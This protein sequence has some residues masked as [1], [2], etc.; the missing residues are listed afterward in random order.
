M[1]HL[2][3]ILIFF[4][5][6]QISY[7][8]NTWSS[9]IPDP[10]RGYPKKLL[11]ASDGGFVLLSRKIDTLPFQTFYQIMVKF[12]SEGQF[13]WGKEYDFGVT[14]SSVNMDGVH[15]TSMIELDNGDLITYGRVVDID[16]TYCYLL[17]TNSNGDSL[18]MQT[19]GDFCFG[20]LQYVNNEIY[21]RHGDS[22]G[23]NYLLK[24][25]SNG[26]ILSQ[27]ELGDYSFEGMVIDEDLNV[28]TNRAMNNT[29]FRKHSIDGTLLKE[30]AY[31]DVGRFLKLGANGYPTAFSYGM[32]QLNSDLSERWYKEPDELLISPTATNVYQEERVLL[33]TSDNG[34]I[35]A[36]TYGLDFIST[37]EQVYII[38]LDE[39]GEWEWGYTYAVSYLPYTGAYDMVEVSDGYVFIGLD[40]STNGDFH[41]VKINKQG[42]VNIDS[43]KNVEKSINFNLSPNPTTDILTLQS[44]NPI[45]GKVRIINLQG[46]ILLQQ[47]I[48]KETQIVIPVISLPSGIYILSF[49]DKE[50]NQI[51]TKKIVKI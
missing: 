4:L 38:K 46:K 8:Q 45:T 44:L 14:P 23:T 42:L 13:L 22:N 39:T 1:K 11:K 30:E 48:I 43:P 41:L 49:L 18:L 19:Y 6:F 24:F 29:I 33:P 5:A 25:N 27:V 9:E 34:F 10:Y 31:P 15:P 40:S 20:N 7:S 28:Y 35:L 2:F 50:S 16:T 32:I 47:E 12:D 36:G 26:D 51:V 37:E 17:K 3:S 21:A